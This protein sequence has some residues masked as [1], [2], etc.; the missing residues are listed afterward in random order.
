MRTIIIAIECGELALKECSDCADTVM[1][2]SVEVSELEVV[3]CATCEVSGT[4]AVQQV[5]VAERCTQSPEAVSLSAEEQR[6]SGWEPL[7][8]NQLKAVA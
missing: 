8:R 6:G 7:R 3:H 4:A 2:E 5:D 1:P